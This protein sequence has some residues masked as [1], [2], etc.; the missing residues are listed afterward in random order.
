MSTCLR[1]LS[2]VMK[3]GE[4]CLCL[5]TCTVGFY[6]TSVFGDQLVSKG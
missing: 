2:G 6:L 4:L 1:S 3:Y 5:I